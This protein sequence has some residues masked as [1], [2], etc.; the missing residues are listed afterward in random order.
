[1]DVCNK[2]KVRELVHIYHY[3]MYTGYQKGFDSLLLTE[4]FIY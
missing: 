2:K 3:V 4:V 1:M